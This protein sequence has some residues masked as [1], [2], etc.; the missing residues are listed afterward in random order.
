MSHCPNCKSELVI[1]R[2]YKTK[3]NY[4]G[5]GYKKFYKKHIKDYLCTKCWSEFNI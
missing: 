3:L 4:K 1:K 5:I 2:K